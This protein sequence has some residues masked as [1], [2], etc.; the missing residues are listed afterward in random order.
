MTGGKNQK[1]I[2]INAVKLFP[3]DLAKKGGMLQAVGERGL[4]FLKAHSKE[5]YAKAR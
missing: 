2:Q 5:K 3:L 4:G 1:G